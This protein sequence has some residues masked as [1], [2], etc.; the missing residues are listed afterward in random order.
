MR[1][2]IGLGLAVLT[3]LGT[4]SLAVAQDAE[5]PEKPQEK[6]EE[7]AKSAPEKTGKTKMK[8]EK[9]TFGGGCFWC[10]EAV[11]ERVP[12]VKSVVSGYAGGS[13]PRPTY[14]LVQTGQTGHAEVVQIEYDPDSASYPDLLDVFWS[15]HDPTTLNQQGPDIG[16]EYRSII[17]YHNDEQKQEAIRSYEKLTAQGVFGA[18]IVTELVPLSKFHKAEPYHQ[19]YYRRNTNAPY[20]RMMIAPKLKKLHLD[21]VKK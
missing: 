11:F 2:F 3:L 16:T 14:Q 9:A 5:T 10:L 13:H 6:T 7:P 4:A 8:T 12:G 1:S 21:K 19:N 20:C 15:C 18:P 17:L